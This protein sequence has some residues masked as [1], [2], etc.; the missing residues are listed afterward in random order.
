MDPGDP[1]TIFAAMYQ[2]RRT[3]W[4]FNG[5][6]PGSGLYRSTDAGENWIELTE[7]L[8]EGD[9]GRIGIDVFRQDGNVVYALVWSRPRYIVLDS[10]AT[11]VTNAPR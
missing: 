3:G 10:S 11:P 9:K 8:P 7:G 2:R 1:N 5:G 6:G 4:G